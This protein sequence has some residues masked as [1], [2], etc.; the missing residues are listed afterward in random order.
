MIFLN[1]HEVR[2]ALPWVPLIEALTEIFREGCT[3][4]TRHHHDLTDGVGPGT[5]LIMPAWRD[6]L[7]LGVKLVTVFPDNRL[8]GL[9]AIAGLY[10]LFDPSRGNAVAALDGGELTARR[11]AATSAMAAKFMARRDAEVLTVVGTGRL[12]TNLI[13]AHSCVR[14]ISKVYVWG[15][16]RDKANTVVRNL[17][18]KRAIVADDLE[19]AVRQ[20]DIVSSATLSTVPLVKGDWLRAG[21]H[22]DLVGAFKPYMRETDAAVWRKADVIVVD[23]HEGTRDEAGD[24]L[25]AEAEGVAVF[26]RVRGSLFELARGQIVGRT[27]DRDITVFKS[28]GAA[29]E[30]IAAAHLAM[31]LSPKRVNAAATGAAIAR[32][33]V[34]AA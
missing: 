21:T 14:R 31:R 17:G 13:E 18:D 27:D 12:C 11:T 1:A 15:R 7:G 6:T 19:T 32:D 2:S 24:I 25:L 5:L 30:D 10:V 20:S 4:P 8:R 26:D 22:L 33:P 9:P 16:D 3:A 34:V 29:Q 23:T 28:V